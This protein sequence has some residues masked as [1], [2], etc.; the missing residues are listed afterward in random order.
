[1]VHNDLVFARWTAKT[2]KIFITNSTEPAWKT[3]HSTSFGQ[4]LPLVP[5]TVLM[6]VFVVVI[7]VV[8]C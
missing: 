3:Q 1:M 7:V 2:C 5:V 8:K 4:L 6:V